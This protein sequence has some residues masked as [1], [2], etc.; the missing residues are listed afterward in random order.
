MRKYINHIMVTLFTISFIQSCKKFVEVDPPIDKLDSELVFS[1]EQT[2][3]SSVLGLYT[4]MMSTLPVISSGGVTIYTGLSADEFYNVNT[5][6]PEI[7]SFTNNELTPANSKLSTDFWLKGYN[8]IY[9]ANACIS[10]LENNSTIKVSLRDQL[11]GESLFIRSFM[12]YY[13]VSLYGDVPLILSTD[14]EANGNAPRSQVDLVFAQLINDL[15]RA[16]SLLTESYPTNGHVR[17]N[18]WTSTA[19]LARIY[20]TLGKW[21][22]AEH[23]ASNIINS[24]VYVLEQNPE[25]VFLPV[26]NEAIWQIMPSANGFNTTEARYFVPTTSAS[27]RPNYPLTTYLQSAFEPGDLRRAKWVNSKVVAG[28]SY[29]YP[30]KYKIRDFGLPVT[31]YYMVF[32]LAEQYLIRAEC[33]AHQGETIN[34]KSDLDFLRQ[35][36]GLPATSANTPDELLNALAQERRVELFAE[37]GHRWLDLKRTKT[38]TTV[39][40]PIKPGWKETDTLYPIPSGEIRRNPSLT[41]NPGY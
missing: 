11:L 19:L 26:S 39:L 12:Y 20:L 41:Q 35:R 40:S 14:Y 9:H 3:T 25:D 1:D 21:D 2:A 18:K 28:Q 5:L 7:A 22:L 16:Q 17:P 33:Y 15:K 27:S 24:G 31:E 23:E 6:D 38:A 4:R 32:R 34:A 13:L 37:W 10:G 8:I 36:A 30:Y 29:Y